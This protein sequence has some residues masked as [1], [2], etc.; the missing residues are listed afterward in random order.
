M[1][2]KRILIV[3]KMSSFLYYQRLK[4]RFA[5]R[6]R[7]VRAR[8]LRQTH[9]RHY[10]TLKAVESF[11]KDRSAVTHKV[12]RGRRTDYDK[13]DL[14][15]TVGGDGTFLEAARYTRNQPIVG[16]NSDPKWSIGRYC[17]A[18]Q[19]NFKDIFA[20]IFQGDYRIRKIMRLLLHI[21]KTKHRVLI[22]NDVLICHRLPAAMSRYQLILDG[23]REEQRGSGIWV[24]AAAGSTGAV[25][26][27]GGKRIPLTSARWQYRPRE[28][29]QGS[30]HRYRLKGGMLSPAQRLEV[31]S[32][33]NDGVI[34][35]DGAHAS[36]PFSA[37]EA[38]VIHPSAV[39]LNF[40]SV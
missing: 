26:S 38:L 40:I 25:L 9:D 5:R 27:A 35:L 15:V 13:Y 10:R 11:F 20:R 7:D 32:F 22:L 14:I 12:W 33:M 6:H 31:I 1:M 28:L 19:K 24:A 23:I 3:Y 2:F 8:R 21:R 17:V 16:I 36:V 37:G 39:P 30:G 34:F 18:S 29:Y 4:T